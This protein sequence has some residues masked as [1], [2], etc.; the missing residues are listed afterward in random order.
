MKAKVIYLIGFMGVGKS[1][2]GR[3]LA[4]RL[5]VQYQD[6]DY[7]LERDQM[8]SIRDIF[9]TFGEKNFRKLERIILLSTPPDGIIST[10]GGVILSKQNREYLK[11]HV[12]VWLDPPWETI[13]NRIKKSNRPIVK[14]NSEQ[15]LHQIYLSRRELYSEVSDIYI[16]LLTSDDIIT[17]IIEKINKLS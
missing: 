9:K 15:A 8:L 6:L 2:I 11:K 7:L 3:C 1:H 13:Y 12:V 17:K 10:G 4:E 5:D 16:D 14:R